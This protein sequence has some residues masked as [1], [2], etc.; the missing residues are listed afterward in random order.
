M[1]GTTVF[2]VMAS[3]NREYNDKIEVM[4]ALAPAVFLGDIASPPARA[5][6]PFVDSLNVRTINSLLL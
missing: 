6:I 3:E 5:L 1:Q 4:H 2:F